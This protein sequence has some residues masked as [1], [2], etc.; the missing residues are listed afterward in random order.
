[1]PLGKDMRSGRLLYASWRTSRSVLSDPV[2]VRRPRWVPA[3][4]AAPGA[5]R[6]TSNKPDTVE[7]TRKL[8]DEV[9]TTWV[10]DPQEVVDEEPTWWWNPLSY[11]TDDTTAAKLAGHFAA[12]SREAGD[13]GDAFFDPAGKDLLAGMLL[14]A[15]PLVTALTVA[16]VEAGERLA[17]TQPGGRLRTPLLCILDEAANV[18]RWGD[19]PDLYSHYGSRGIPIMS[20]FQSWS[21]G[22]DVFTLAGMRKLFSAAS[23]VVYLGGVKETEWLRE[24]SELIGD[25]DHETVS[26]S[27]NKGV[28]STNTTNSRRRILDTSELAELPRGCAILMASGLRTSMVRTAPWYEG[29][30]A[31]K[32]QASI[33]AYDAGERVQRTASTSTQA[34]SIPAAGNPWL[35][36]AS[37]QPLEA[38]DGR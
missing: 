18:C 34:P 24:L 4:L 26:A 15:A 2:L 16:V 38:E 11:V 29:P 33:A 21:Q 19:L 37:V 8:R 1:V 25:Y 10:F 17:K 23:E 14:A 22:V 6:P 35:N 13:K 5:L 28:R 30:D 32:V 12:G 7:T 3:I 27:H 9:G 20:I 31:A 36:A